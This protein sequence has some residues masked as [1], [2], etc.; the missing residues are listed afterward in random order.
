MTRPVSR[1][2]WFQPDDS[3]SG[4]WMTRCHPISRDAVLRPTRSTTC[5]ERGSNR[6]A[7]GTNSEEHMNTGR[8][9]D[10]YILWGGS[11]SFYTGK[12]RSYLIKKR[13]PYR[14][15][16]PSHAVFQT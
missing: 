13:I 2:A 7:V 15:F 1:G 4:L 11:L 3:S 5:L 16:F 12:V 6:H 9:N 10:T 14:E 8:T